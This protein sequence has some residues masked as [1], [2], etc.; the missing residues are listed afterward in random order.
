MFIQREHWKTR[1]CLPLCRR[2]ICLLSNS[3]E[4]SFSSGEKVGQV[5]FIAVD[6]IL[7]FLAWVAGM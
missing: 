7:V 1:Q 3:T 4:I 2:L 6:K 5:C